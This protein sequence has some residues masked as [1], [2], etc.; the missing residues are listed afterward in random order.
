MKVKVVKQKKV[1]LAGEDYF[2][3]LQPNIVESIEDLAKIINNCVPEVK[4]FYL[5]MIKNYTNMTY[6]PIETKLG[7]IKFPFYVLKNTCLVFERNI[8]FNN[9]QEL[10]EYIK[11]G[12]TEAE[13]EEV[14]E[15][16]IAGDQP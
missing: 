6:I 8:T 4:N 9:R 14:R 15:D 3:L 16:H 7:E 2:N 13:R 10:L 5:A 12:M 11:T 1:K